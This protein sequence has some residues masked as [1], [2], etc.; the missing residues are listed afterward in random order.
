MAENIRILTPLDGKFSIQL[1]RR[2]GEPLT[3]R[4]VNSQTLVAIPR[5]EPLF[6]FRARDKYAVRVLKSYLQVCTNGECSR[7]HLKGIEKKIEEFQKYGLTHPDRMKE[8][9][10]SLRKDGE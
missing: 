6:V 10:S 3:P 1:E 7:E 5:E 4:L 9:G 8:P 2:P